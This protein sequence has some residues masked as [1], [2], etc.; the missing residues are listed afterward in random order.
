MEWQRSGYRFSDAFPA[1]YV[2][3][4]CPGV[5]REAP[6]STLSIQAELAWVH[7]NAMN[8][9]GFF[10]Q[11]LADKNLPH[12]NGQSLGTLVAGL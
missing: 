6:G 12:H 5:F 11:S 3:G 10:S 9:R 4:F 1:R 2:T 7:H 8:L